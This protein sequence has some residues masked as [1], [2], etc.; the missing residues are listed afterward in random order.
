[1]WAPAFCGICKVAPC[2][3]GGVYANGAVATTMW[4]SVQ[5]KNYRLGSSASGAHVAGAWF[6]LV[7]QWSPFIP[8]ITR[9]DTMARDTRLNAILQLVGVELARE[10][11][12]CGTGMTV[13]GQSCQR[14]VVNFGRV[15]LCAKADKRSAG[16]STNATLSPPESECVRRAA[17]LVEVWS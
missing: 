16:G 6:V 3:D 8:A 7:C 11:A 5:Y 15:C 4:N 9:K 14:G 12:R 1:M 17:N 10:R 13:A 2:H